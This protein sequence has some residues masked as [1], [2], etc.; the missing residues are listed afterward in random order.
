MEWI[1]KIA[2]ICM[3]TALTAVLLERDTPELALLLTLG[4]VV[5]V[6]AFAL[7]FY[8]E[9][10][11]LLEELLDRSGLGGDLF[12]PLLKIIAI[13]LV[14]RL[15][16]DICRDGGKKALASVVDIAGTFCALIAASP[17]LREVLALL[18]GLGG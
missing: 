5:V 1:I 8:G 9:V 14:A 13:S 12:L 2:V 16:S 17:L 7:S 6:M 11:A 15:G 18:S 3:V 10:E 4:A